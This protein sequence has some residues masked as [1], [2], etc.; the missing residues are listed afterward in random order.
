MLE[1]IE[2]SNL[3]IFILGYGQIRAQFTMLTWRVQYMGFRW[4]SDQPS[5]FIAQ[6]PSPKVIHF[7]ALPNKARSKNA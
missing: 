1:I 4:L 6:F 7:Y 2:M 5:C 3:N